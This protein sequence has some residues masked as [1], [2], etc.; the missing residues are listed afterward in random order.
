MAKL[1]SKLSPTGFVSS[2]DVV[3][4]DTFASATA[5]N[6]PSAE[7]VKS[8]VGSAEGS[9]KAWVHANND[10]SLDGS[11]NVSSS[12][13]DGVGLYTYNYTN[14][15][16]DNDYAATGTIRVGS[17][18]VRVV[19]IRSTYTGKMGVSSARASTNTY[20]DREHLAVVHGDLA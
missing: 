11:F 14:A 3:D 1:S 20:E 10:A 13:D 9:A 7:S 18:T 15:F 19:H 8:Y 17:Q 12:V 16:A 4:D 2:S 6:I 5:T